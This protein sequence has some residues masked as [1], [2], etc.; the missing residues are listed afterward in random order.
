VNEKTLIITE[1]LTKKLRKDTKY[2]SNVFIIAQVF[3]GSLTLGRILRAT[4]GAEIS[5]DKLKQ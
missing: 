2:A 5:L 3:A 4:S 1:S